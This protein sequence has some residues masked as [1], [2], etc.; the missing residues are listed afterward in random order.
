[1]FEVLP[2]QVHEVLPFAHHEVDEG[3][4]GEAKK[5]L[6]VGQKKQSFQ[7]AFR[8]YEQASTMSNLHGLGFNHR[9]KCI[10]S[11]NPF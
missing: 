3:S 1:M 9:G 4:L 5:W 6:H 2:P 11:I 10:K 8:K 7:V